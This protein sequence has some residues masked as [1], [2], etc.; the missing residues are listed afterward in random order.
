[1]SSF[2]LVLIAPC[3]EFP[4]WTVRGWWSFI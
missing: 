4:F 2:M 3:S 1:M